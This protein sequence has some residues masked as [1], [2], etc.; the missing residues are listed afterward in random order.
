M[1]LGRV[2]AAGD[3]DCVGQPRH[4][5]RPRGRM[6]L[7]ALGPKRMRWG[8]DYPPVSS[9]EGYDNSLRVPLEYFADL[10]Q[11]DR[12]SIFG[13]TAQAVWGLPAVN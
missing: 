8:S 1:S 10:S 3:A 13:A 6:P 12:E 5:V 2:R 11:E 9:R 4:P 7:D